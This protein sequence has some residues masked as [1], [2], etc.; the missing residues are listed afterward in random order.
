MYSVLLFIDGKTFNNAFSA[1]SKGATTRSVITGRVGESITAGIFK[2]SKQ[3][4]AASG[5]ADIVG[6]K[7]DT[8]ISLFNVIE[9]SIDK[10]YIEDLRGVLGAELDIEAKA[11]SKFLGGFGGSERGSIKI[12]QATPSI[13]KLDPDYLRRAEQLIVAIVEIGLTKRNPAKVETIKSLFKSLEA[14]PNAISLRE[15]E[16][17][18]FKAVGGTRGRSVIQ[19]AYERIMKDPKK[20]KQFMASPFGNTIRDKVRNINVQVNARIGDK[21]VTFFQTFFNLQFSDSDIVPKPAAGSTYTFSLSSAFEKKLLEETRRKLEANAIGQIEADVN[22]Y[23]DFY[24]KGKTS[25]QAILGLSSSIGTKEILKN[26]SFNSLTVSVPT[27]GSI[28]LNFGINASSL[29]ALTSKKIPQLLASNISTTKI[30][31]GRFMSAEKLTPILQAAIYS[32]MKKAGSPRPP[33]I[34]YRTGTFLDS[35]R[36]VN[37]NYRSNVISYFSNPIYYSLEKYGYKVED[38][39]T[40]SLREV[41]QQIYSRQFNLTR[42]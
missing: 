13:R 27:G 23:L 24:V 9:P 5:R 17:Q 6:V 3:A 33:T 18:I 2:S 16:A 34:T 39:I 11:T 1:A 42:A 10:S 14:D 22:N 30:K 40:G 25:L 26:L 19:N 8:V 28:P 31:K 12:T 41:T 21:R 7:T 29:L 36:V 37:I 15:F 4:T 35:V 32:K 38:L 20:F